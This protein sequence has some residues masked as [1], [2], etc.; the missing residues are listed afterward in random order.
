MNL[1]QAWL[2]ELATMALTTSRIGG[3]IVTSPFPGKGVPTQVKVGM[4]FVFGY[5]ATS[6]IPA[7]SLQLDM[8]LVGLSVVEAC[9]GILIGLVFRLTFS[10]AEMVGSSFTQSLGL[11]QAHIYDPMLESDDG[12]P[13]RI[14]TLLAMMLVFSLGTH[15][16]CIAYVLES[17]H[18]LPVGHAYSITAATPLLVDYA[19]SAIAAGVRLGLPVAGVALSVQITLALIA[20]ASPQMQVFSVASSLAV[21]AGMI[22]VIASIDDVAKGIG[23]ELTELAPRID[24][25]LQAVR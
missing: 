1:P 12:V 25:V 11:S 22:A 17:F 6:T 21:A 18:A 20:R 8:K 15:R 14:A 5:L 16:I 23:G 3:M 24:H 13:G 7:A 4:V 10:C 19:G 2:A 9:L